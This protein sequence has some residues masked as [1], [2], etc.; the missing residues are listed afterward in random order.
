MAGAEASAIDFQAADADGVAVSSPD[1][2]VRGFGEIGDAV[3]EQSIGGV[4]LPPA[5]IF[6]PAEPGRGAC[7][8]PS[9]AVQQQGLH[10]LVISSGKLDP[11]EPPPAAAGA[12]QVQA[13]A[14]AH[15][16]PPPGIGSQRIYP[17]VQEP[18][19]GAITLGPARARVHMEQPAGR[20]TG[21]PGPIPAPRQCQGLAG[22]QERVF[23]YL[24][25]AAPGEKAAD[26]GLRG[27]PERAAVVASQR[28]D[29]VVA[30]SLR[31]GP[32]FGALVAQ[33]THQSAA[34]QSNPCRP[35][36]VLKEEGRSE[37][38]TS[39]LQSLR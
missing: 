16:D 4:E 14:R 19:F 18:G 35:F 17:L 32:C 9:A 13:K 28:P 6:E 3:G 34:I 36:D 8:Y 1:R 20:L 38:H 5:S 30:Q 11:C 25:L 39:E 7:P 24:P 22:G 23:P 2:M 27:G 26:A 37:E 33:P 10:D 12:S 29:H 21:P 31:F 15:P